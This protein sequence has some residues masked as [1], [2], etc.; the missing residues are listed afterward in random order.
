MP[1]SDERSG[2]RAKL[3]TD[4]IAAD[5]KTLVLIGMRGAGKTHLGT[6]AAAALG[7]TF[8]DLDHVYEAR[9]GPIIDTA[10]TLGWPIFRER[11]VALLKE[12]LAEHPTGAVIATGGGVVETS[13]GRDVLRA[14][15]PVVQAM[16]NIED[17]EAYLN[18]DKTR[19]SLGEAPRD[20]YKR[21]APWYYECADFDLLPAPGAK[22]EADFRAQDK[23]LLRLLRRSFGTE[24]PP[25]LPHDNSFVLSLAAPRLE[26][27]LP[28]PAEALRNVDAVELRVDAL[29]DL[30]TLE[31]Q[32]QL[33]LLR[34]HVSLPLIFSLRSKD[35]GGAFGGSEEEYVALLELGARAGVDWVEVEAARDGAAVQALC[36]RFKERGVRVVGSRYRSQCSD[37]THA[38]D[39]HHVLSSCSLQGAAS[40]ARFVGPAA[41]PARAL[42]L[43]AWAAEAYLSIPHVCVTEG[44]AS[45]LSHVL[46]GTWTP[47]THPLLPANV[48]T[49]PLAADDLVNEAWALELCS[50]IPDANTATGRA[51]AARSFPLPAATP[52]RPPC[53]FICATLAALLSLTA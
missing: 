5:Q 16:K 33:A 11:E 30:R 26:E 48:A 32:R 20:V 13:A 31:V 22:S 18:F 25:P 51:P 53:S 44:A 12:T 15:W 40:V 28:L 27:V 35:H 39:V 10:K 50:H 42:Q 23:R 45:R 43:R 41:T 7:H 38:A 52:Q 34:C 2:K 29:A 9:H 36:A 37:P 49:A 19:P 14:Y 17:V 47:V 6:M 24:P 3:A 4:E 21:R 1:S 8:I 46:N